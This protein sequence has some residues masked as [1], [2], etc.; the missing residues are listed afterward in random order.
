MAFL[1]ALIIPSILTGV[2]EKSFGQSG[3]GNYDLTDDEVFGLYEQK[4][5]PDV[6]RFFS[7]HTN[8]YSEKEN[9]NDDLKVAFEL[10]YVSDHRTIFDIA[11]AVVDVD[12]NLY[13]S[14]RPVLIIKDTAQFTG[15]A[16]S[17]LNNGMITIEDESTSIKP[18]TF[19]PA[20]EFVIYNHDSKNYSLQHTF[21]YGDNGYIIVYAKHE[22]NSQLFMFAFF[23][24][25]FLVCVMLLLRGRLKY[26]GEIEQSFSKIYDSH[27]QHKISIKYNNELTQVAE[28]INE[29]TLLLKKSEEREHSFLLNIS[30]DLRT[31]LN[32]MMGYMQLIRDKKY[33]SDEE[34]EYYLSQIEHKTQYLKT[35]IH[36]FFNMMRLKRSQYELTLNTIS[37]EELLRQVIEG[38]LPTL[39]AAQLTIKFDFNMINENQ[40]CDVTLIS[41]VFENLLSNAIKYSFKNSTIVVRTTVDSRIVVQNV[42]IENFE[43]GPQDVLFHEFYKGNHARTDE[44]TGL[45]LFIVK[46]IIDLHK[47]QIKAFQEQKYFTIEITMSNLD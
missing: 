41:R 45:G 10:P 7:E 12:G 13:H 47:W 6:M 23:I 20:S 14:N 3:F 26:I 18:L 24:I 40:L 37:I 30:H 1:I 46:E 22:N 33:D 4:L 21:S 31:P 39:S 34:L 8:L 28:A 43:E 38:Y 15:D 35:L 16:T 32:S 9:L 2:A 44:G 27:Y 19:S 11:I 5:L 17:F 42:P 25:C 29:F 36:D